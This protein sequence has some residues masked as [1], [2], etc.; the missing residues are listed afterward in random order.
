VGFNNRELNAITAARENTEIFT[1]WGADNTLAQRNDEIAALLE[2]NFAGEAV[3]DWTEFISDFPDQMNLQELRD[4]FYSSSLE[5]RTALL[6]S[7]YERL[8]LPYAEGGEQGDRVR[9]MS[10]HSSKGLSG[11]VVFIPGL[12]ELVFP[13]RAVQLV[14]GRVLEAARLLYVAITRAKGVCILSRTL[15]RTLQGRSLQMTP[16]RFCAALNRPFTRERALV[17][18]AD[19]VARIQGV[20][21]LL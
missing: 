7:V 5:Y 3:A 16:S 18:S 8:D 21:A 2:G 15:R 9:I 12:E 11:K 20:L 19:E 4:Y 13:T 17:I 6:N 10:F 14:P 1:N